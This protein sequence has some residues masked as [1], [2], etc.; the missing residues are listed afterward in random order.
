VAHQLQLK[1]RF[2]DRHRLE[3]ELLRLDDAPVVASSP[4]LGFELVTDGH[5][6]RRGFFG[7]R[8]GTRQ[9]LVVLAVLAVHPVVVLLDT[10]QQLVGGQVDGRVH[11]GR[12]LL[13]SDH[14]SAREDRGLAHTGLGD[15]RVLLDLQ[16]KLYARHLVDLAVLQEL[17]HAKDLLLRV[18]PQGVG[19]G[20]VA[21]LDLGLHRHRSF[22]IAV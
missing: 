8:D 13:G 6:R 19:H 3:G 9:L 7:L 4:E 10:A 17:A 14:R 5:G 11:V 18:V 15:T 22:M 20:D 12:A 16:L 2:D 21:A 1:G